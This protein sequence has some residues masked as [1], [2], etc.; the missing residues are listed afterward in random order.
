MVIRSPTY[1][2]YQKYGEWLY[3]FDLYRLDNFENFDLIGGGEILDNSENICLIEWP[4]ILGAHYL[5]TKTFHI[6]LLEDGS[7]RIEIRAHRAPTIV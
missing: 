7:R 4:E 2:Y 5:A 6:T 3:H 1:T